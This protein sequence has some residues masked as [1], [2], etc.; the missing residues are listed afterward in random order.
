MATLFTALG[1]M[2]QLITQKEVMIC[3][4]DKIKFYNEKM[5]YFQIIAYTKSR[6]MRYF[7]ATLL[8]HTASAQLFETRLLF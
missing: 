1:H 4:V 2:K 5:A 7:L 8:L 6:K 3:F